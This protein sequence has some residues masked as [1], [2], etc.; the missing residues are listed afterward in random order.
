M[1]HTGDADA[2]AAPESWNPSD[3]AY[4]LTRR[5]SGLPFW[6]TLILHGT[7]ALADAVR[8]PMTTTAYAVRQLRAIPGV[9]VVLE[10]EL[11]VVLFRKSGWDRGRWQQWS[12]ELLEQRIAFVAPTTWKGE[13]VGRLAFLH[14]LT[15]NA[16][17]DEVLDTLR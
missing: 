2:D 3:Y 6:F 10:P 1:L 13:T 9:E 16:I 5:P 8:A 14:P 4:Q 12:A 7:E 11:T 17:V 15:T